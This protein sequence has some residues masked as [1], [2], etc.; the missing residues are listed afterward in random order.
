MLFR[1]PSRF[2]ALTH[3]L[4]DALHLDQLLPRYR[5]FA[6]ASARHGG[7]GVALLQEDVDVRDPNLQAPW[8]NPKRLRRRYRN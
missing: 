8:N 3:N 4:M 6:R 5:R 2:V 7:V 1:R